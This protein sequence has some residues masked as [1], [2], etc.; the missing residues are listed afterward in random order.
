M[1]AAETADAKPPKRLAKFHG[2]TITSL[3]ASPVGYFIA[4][5][6]LDGWFHVY[7]VVNKVLIFMQDLKEPITSLIWLPLRVEL[8][9]LIPIFFSQK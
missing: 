1:K 8:K 3:L 7:D 6:S 4:T 2:D 9:I 5:T